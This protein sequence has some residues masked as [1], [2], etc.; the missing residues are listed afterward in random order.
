LKTLERLG[1]SLTGDLGCEYGGVS[2][3]TNSA[4]GPTQSFLGF[5]FYN[6][7]WFDNDR[8]GLTIG[9]GKINNPGRYLVLLPPIN[10]ATAASGTPYFTENPG[11]PYKAWDVSGTFDWMPRQAITFRC[12][13][14]YRAANVPYFGWA[15][16][17]TPPGGNRVRRDP[18]CQSGCRICGRTKIV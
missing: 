7:L 8:Y 6:W 14:N 2:C 5:M 11:D 12:E 4:K 3:Y 15:G 18:W 10:G 17:V 16:G 1:F 13:Y 9:G